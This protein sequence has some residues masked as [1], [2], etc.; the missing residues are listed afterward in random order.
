MRALDPAATLGRG[1][2]VVQ[3][4]SSGQVVSGVAQVTTG[5]QLSITVAD[6]DIPAIAGGNADKPREKEARKK[7]KPRESRQ[8]M[9]RLL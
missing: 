2:S 3:N 8:L 7:S 4:L 9:E 5:D 6:G 1:F